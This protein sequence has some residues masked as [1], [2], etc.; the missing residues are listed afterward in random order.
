MWPL[1]IIV[2]S[3]GF[4]DHLGFQ[5]RL[6]PLTLQALITELVMKTFDEPILPGLAR[7]NENRANMVLSQPDLYSLCGEFTAIIGTQ[8]S[9]GRSMVQDLGE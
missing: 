2:Q 3:P 8:E 6:K 1:G 5:E 4:D 7:R 9:W